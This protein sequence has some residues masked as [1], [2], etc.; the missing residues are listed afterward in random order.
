MEEGIEG[1]IAIDEFSVKEGDCSGK[2]TILFIKHYNP[3]CYQ[4][5]C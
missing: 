1:D 5:F 4:A 2:H 3:I